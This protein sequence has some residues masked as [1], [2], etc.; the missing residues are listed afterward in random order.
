MKH[1]FT[2]AVSLVTLLLSAGASISFADNPLVR[3]IYT[4]D[5]APLVYH[6]R[7]YIFTGHDEG[8]NGDWTLNGWHVLSSADMVNW[9]E[10]G[11]V[12]SV[13]DVTWLNPHQAWAAQCVERNGKFYFY[14]CDSGEI[15]VAVA[16]SIL[17]PYKDALGKPLISNKTPGACPGNDNIDPTVFI[18]DDGQAYIYWGTDR[19][20]RQAKLKETMVEIEGAITVPDGLN[21]FFEASWVHKRRGVYYYSYAA[22]NSSGNDWPS[23]IDYATSTGPLGPWTYRGTLNGTAG[24]GTN[25]SGIISYKDQW[26][27]VYHT[28]YLSGGVPW[29]RSVQ[30]NYL[31]YNDD[32]SIKKIM[33]DSVGVEAVGPSPFFDEKYYTLRALH[34]GKLLEVAD[35]SMA[36]HANVRQ[37]SDNGKYRQ[38][39]KI[40]EEERGIYKILNRNSRLALDA[41]RSNN[42]VLQYDH[43]GGENQKWKI[44]GTG[45]GSYYVVCRGNNRVLEVYYA[46]KQDGANVQHWPFNG[47]TC[48]MWDIVPADSNEA[49]V[50]LSNNERL[51]G[52]HK[53]KKGRI[54]LLLPG[55]H[56]YPGTTF[57]DLHGRVSAM[58]ASGVISSGVYLNYGKP[59]QPPLRW[60]QSVN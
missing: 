50:V 13:Q 3:H 52:A 8:G 4:A 42:N 46:E 47:E 27:F 7:F 6:G 30:I 19:V 35:A 20:A 60:L 16:D 56:G 21:R 15:G 53:Q 59:A 33:Q 5:P 49:A 18:D 51:Q 38:H 14:I 45:N 54:Q 28:D 37:F 11:A 2:I 29:K 55:S 17:G 31:Y 1:R 9:I 44:T 43:W 12:L 39:W 58:P 25:H 40:V 36:N 34:S 22:S 23:N 26:Y 10:H 48:Q 41:D 24:T 57:I 32:G